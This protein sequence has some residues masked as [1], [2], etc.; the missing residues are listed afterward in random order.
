MRRIITFVLIFAALLAGVSASPPGM[1]LEFTIIE[2]MSGVCS[3]NVADSNVTSLV[4]SARID[5]FSATRGNQLVHNISFDRSTTLPSEMVETRGGT[6]VVNANGLDGSTYALTGT[7]NDATESVRLINF[8]NWTA[9]FGSAGVWA[10]YSVLYDRTDIPSGQADIGY[11]RIAGGGCRFEIGTADGKSPQFTDDAGTKVF[12]ND[13][14]INNLYRLRVETD[15]RNFKV[16]IENATNVNENASETTPPEITYYNLTS[17]DNGC[18]SWNTDRNTACNSTSVLPTVKFN[19]S[20][21]A[22][23]AIGKSD[24]SYT[25]AGNSR[26]CTGAASGEGTKEH[27]CTLILEDE[28]ITTNA[29]IYISCK[30]ANNNENLTSTSG[31]LNISVSASILESNARAQLDLGASNA[32]ASGY[33]SFS[34]QK[35]YARNSANSQSTGRFDKVFKKLSRLWALNYLSGADDYVNMVNITPVLYT[36][37]LSNKTRAQILNQTELLI[38][39]TK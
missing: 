1:R 25:N 3:T 23:C 26:N 9:G 11:F 7:A 28:I 5:N 24:L 2:N 6:P 10:N 33:S 37:E 14:N 19:T 31:P 39:A 35:I 32:L 29:S 12:T 13:V 27:F 36:L 4:N 20:E 18:E 8:F 30:D 38:N 17:S 21:D 15:G 22:W 16:F 34:D